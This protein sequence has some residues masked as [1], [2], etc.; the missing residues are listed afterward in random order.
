MVF[1]TTFQLEDECLCCAGGKHFWYGANTF[2]LYVVMNALV[3]KANV[4]K[5]S[6]QTSPIHTQLPATFNRTYMR[7]K[8][9]ATHRYMWSPMKMDGSYHALVLTPFYA[10]PTNYVS[11]STV[12][13]LKLRMGQ[14]ENGHLYIRYRS[15]FQ[16]IEPE[17]LKRYGLLPFTI[18]MLN[19][20]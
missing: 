10:T 3:L 20:L 16:K 7:L 4:L 19:L 5:T 17:E 9:I 2:V 18:L 6:M 14:I 8:L 11:R 13:L 12:V 1:Y 15:S